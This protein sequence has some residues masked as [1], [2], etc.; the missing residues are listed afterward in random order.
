M[1]P[2]PVEWSSLALFNRIFVPEDDEL[3]TRPP[4]VDRV[5][6]NYQSL[7]QSNKRLSAVDRQRLDDHMARIE[8]LQRRLEVAVSCGD[9]VV[10]TDD[11]QSRWNNPQYPFEPQLQ[12][13][14]WRLFN[15]VIVAAFAC[16][17]SRIATLRVT[18]TFSPHEGSWHDDIAHLA[19][20]PDGGA[21]QVLVDA[22]Q[23]TFESVFLDLVAKLDAIE[24]GDG[25]TM[26]DHTFAQWTQESGQ[27]THEFVDVPIITAGSAGGVMRTGQYI[28]YRNQNQVMYPDPNIVPVLRPGLTYNQWLGTVLQVMG[29]PPSEYE[30]DPQ[31]GYPYLYV[32]QD[33]GVMYPQAVRTAAGEPLPW[34]LS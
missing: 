12:H 20:Q 9:I 14:F 33:R 2:L 15:D 31:G 28:D 29:I 4:V 22:H 7:R 23:H 8:E 21:Q 18:D 25:T 10:P 24:E 19:N 13:E 26:L 34:I 6:A 27:N 11:S 32:G 16:G 1:Q 17:T 3:T 30:V 5:M